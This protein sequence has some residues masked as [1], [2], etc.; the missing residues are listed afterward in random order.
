MILSIETS[1]SLCAVAFSEGGKTLAEFSSDAP[2]Q[3]ATLIGQFVEKGLKQTGKSPE[4]LAV[5][6]GPGSFT[7]LRIGLSYAQGFCFGRDIPIVGVSNHQVLAL[8]NTNGTAPL[9]TIIDARRDEVYLAKHK[10][11][12][13][14]EIESHQIVPIG[15]LPEKLS[16]PA[17]L[18][19][20]QGQNLPVEVKSALAQAGINL[21]E[22]GKY[23][24]AALAQIGQKLVEK[25][26]SDNLETLEPMYIRP[27]AGV[28]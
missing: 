2:M 8:N 26:G 16:G 25:R 6:I 22:D 4:L 20:M 11:D 10:A 3:H 18:I 21:K 19:C 9:Y 5:A 12:D 13:T 24:A 14:F 23:A 27:F 1:S 17:Q 28:Q 7:G 15:Q